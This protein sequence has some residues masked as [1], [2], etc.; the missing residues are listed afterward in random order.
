MASTAKK[1]IYQA[2]RAAIVASSDVTDLLGDASAVY[3][4][5]PPKKAVFPCIVMGIGD[6]P[7]P[8]VS[9]MG[10]YEYSAHIEV[11]GADPDTLDD[12]IDELDSVLFDKPQCGAWQTTHMRILVC[13]RMAA[14]PPS[15]TAFADTNQNS[16]ERVRT[17]WRL[18]ATPK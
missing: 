6:N 11:W 16:V 4:T 5:C 8:A 17:T 9:N 14:E 18:R 10:V 13:R 7:E 2:V 15:R 12:I 1:E 3:R